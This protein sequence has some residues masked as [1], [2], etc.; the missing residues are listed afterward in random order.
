MPFIVSSEG[1]A[2]RQLPTSGPHLARLIQLIDLG[3]QPGFQG[4][5]EH[6]IML[7]HELTDDIL[8]D[9]PAKGKPLIIS[10]EFTLSVKPM[11]NLR[12]KFLDVLFPEKFADT[13]GEV[14]IDLET[15]LGLG[16]QVNIIHKANAQH[17]G[18]K[19]A[20]IVSVAPLRK[21]DVVPEPVNPVL[22]IDIHNSPAEV[23]AKLPKWIQRKANRDDLVSE[24]S[25]D[26]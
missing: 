24:A 5:M 21:T 4:K 9:G 8:V 10:H 1:S 14:Q 23:V 15:L 7:T 17:A 18:K 22:L 2:E 12:K 6:K 13:K 20:K 26:F 19:T 25:G 3:M 11:A 16:L